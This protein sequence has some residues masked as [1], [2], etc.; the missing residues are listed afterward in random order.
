MWSGGPNGGLPTKRP[1]PPPAAT[2]IAPNGQFVI[3]AAEAARFVAARDAPPDSFFFLPPPN[4]PPTD[5]H[6]SRTALAL[7]LLA[8]CVAMAAAADEPVPAAD[9]GSLVPG[10]E[11][12][13]LEDTD[14]VMK[15]AGFVL[16]EETGLYDAPDSLAKEDIKRQV[17]LPENEADHAAFVNMLLSQQH[18]MVQS[19]YGEHSIPAALSFLVKEYQQ[20]AADVLA[21]L[22]ISQPLVEMTWLAEHVQYKIE[23]FNQLL[24]HISP[25]LQQHISLGNPIYSDQRLQAN[26]RTQAVTNNAWWRNEPAFYRKGIN[27]LSV[28]PSWANFRPCLINIGATGASAS[29]RFL[30]VNPRL[31]AVSAKGASWDPKFMKVEPTL[32]RVKATGLQFQPRMFNIA[33]SLVEVSPTL[34]IKDDNI[35]VPKT[36]RWGA[37]VLDFSGKGKTV[38]WTKGK[39]P[40]PKPSELKA[41]QPKIPKFNKNALKYQG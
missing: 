24:K 8:G 35:R 32:I 34:T 13:S 36:E 14:R 23:E 33:P 7:L 26:N 16:N 29:P 18:A 5:H 2:M 4:P 3:W 9:D 38:D 22:G 27:A 39:T 31:I 12:L 20:L 28:S 19:E 30:S 10:T 15:E 37:P 40:I 11:T 21:I 41:L 6:P 25:T 17:L 1:P